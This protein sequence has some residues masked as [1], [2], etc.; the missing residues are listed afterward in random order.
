[1]PTKEEVTL[2]GVCNTK[3]SMK[4][5]S[6][7]VKFEKPCY[8]CKKKHCI[9]HKKCALQFMNSRRRD[10][11]QLTSI[12]LDSFKAFRNPFYC[13]QCREMQCFKCER[14][15]KLYITSK[16]GTKISNKKLICPVCN[17]KWCASTL[18]CNQLIP[19]GKTVQCQECE[20][21]NPS[22]TKKKVTK[23]PTKK[24]KKKSTSSTTSNT[25]TT[26][27][28]CSNKGKE[29]TSNSSKNDNDNNCPDP[30]AKD[31]VKEGLN[32]DIDNND[33]NK[34]TDCPSKSIS[35]SKSNSPSMSH[36]PIKIK[37]AR[38]RASSRRKTKNRRFVKG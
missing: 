18:R 13:A 24:K 15:H 31:Q 5:K 26:P 16:T 3:V 30:K 28:K 34:N 36:S 20:V 2:C 27:D 22:T 11:E 29:T 21:K 23:K 25:N 8:C 12:S 35:P 37:T 10:D 14:N 7:P 17:K 32:D 4:S 1:M 19:K 9:L 33:D 6:Y 38:K